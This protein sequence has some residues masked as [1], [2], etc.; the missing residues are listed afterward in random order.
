MLLTLQKLLQKAKQ[1]SD[2]RDAHA[3]A[4]DLIESMLRHNAVV[5]IAA[6]R[7]AGARDPKINRILAEQ[8]PRPTMGSWKNFLQM[9]AHADLKLFPEQFWEK[10]LQPLTKKVS[11]PD[12]SAA[13]AGLKKLADQDVFASHETMAES[14]Q[15]LC[16]TLECLEAV[17]TYRNR[18]AG[19]GTHELPESALKF[20]PTFLKGTAAICAHLN[21]LWLAFPVYLAKQAKLYGRTYFRLTP[22]VEAEVIGELQATIPGM[23]EDRLYICF[24][25]R[26]HPEVESLYPAALWEEDDILFANGTKGLID[27]H[28]IGYAS[29]RSFETSIYEEDYRTFMEPFTSP[30]KTTKPDIITPPSLPPSRGKKRTPRLTIVLLSAVLCVLVIIV[31]FEMYSRFITPKHQIRSIAVLAFRNISD[32]PKQEYLCEGIAETI[33]NTLTQIE[34]LNVPARTSAFSF[35]GKNVTIAEIGKALNVETVLE[36]S[37]QKEGNN[38]RISVQLI[39]VDNGYHLWSKQYNRKMESI[40]AIQDEISQAIVRELKGRLLN[41][42]KKVIGKRYT[43]NTKAYELYLQGRSYWNKRN[44]EGLKI[45]I[46]YFQHAISIDPFYALA[47]AG[48]AD[49]YNM[50]GYYSYLSPKE[51]YSG[52]KIAAEKALK[53]DDTLAEAYASLGWV[54]LFFDWD[55]PEAQKEFE[56]AID[57]NPNYAEAHS[58]FSVYL[59][60]TGQ[61]DDAIAEIDRAYELDPLSVNIITT[62]GNVRTIVGRY[63]EA[64]NYYNK[65]LKMDPSFPLTY[66]HL[67][68][69]NIYTMRWQEAIASLNE[70]MILSGSTPLSIGFLGYAYAMSGRKDEAL[71]MLKRLNDLSMERYVSPFF[72][73]LIFMGLGEKDQ[74]F[75]YLEQAYE[76]RETWLIT[77]QFK[78]IFKN[79]C[80]DPRYNALMK[81]IGLPE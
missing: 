56:H 57:L 52:A 31:G 41:D 48:I 10:F 60:I 63:N 44:E 54:R 26:K 50:L 15:V 45:G 25:D 39:K 47:Y 65:A 59:R 18:F 9:L 42:E 77:N 55:W 68:Q 49:C 70:F 32:D 80:S 81:K 4:L 75:K 58:W 34:G 8:L 27:I 37:V 36:G 76:D 21:T 29:Q 40:F 17:V 53:I 66:F 79:I 64:M 51:A 1:I 23:E 62:A 5:A 13:Y 24:G 30:E 33:I 19:H 22:L 20:A 69:N 61:F 16:T 46:Q 6:Y 67:G 74:V 73:A 14:E 78:L 38:I 28:Y 43:K 71:K 12:I 3:L 11:N 72:K 7:H 35:K 2:P